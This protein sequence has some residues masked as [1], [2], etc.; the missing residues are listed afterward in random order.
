MDQKIRH[1]SVEHQ[2]IAFRRYKAIV[3]PLGPHISKETLHQLI[4]YFLVNSTLQKVYDESSIQASR[5]SAFFKKECFPFKLI[6][7]QMTMASAPFSKPSLNSMNL[8][9][10]MAEQK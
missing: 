4:E 7:M 3:V 5:K 8:V 9:E 10:N 1:N 6:S 2:D